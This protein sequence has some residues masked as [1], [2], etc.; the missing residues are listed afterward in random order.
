MKKSLHNLLYIAAAGL[1]SLASCKK[2]QA[3]VTFVGGT[4]P[5]LTATASDSIPLPISDTTATAV[6]FSWTNPNYQFSDGLS[7]MDVTY[8]LEFDTTA[9]FNSGANAGPL[10]T[11]GISSSLSQTYTVAQLNAIVANDMGL[12][13]FNQHS[14]EVRVESFMQP[15][16]STSAPVG[17]LNSA[18]LTFT[19]NPYSPPPA[20]APPPNDSLYIVGSA[21]LP[22]DW[23]NPIPAPQIASETFTEVKPTLYTITTTL[24]GGQEYKLISQN[25]GSW[26]YQWSVASADTYPTGGPFVFNGANC[27]APANT[28]SYTIVVNFQTGIF[29]VTA[30]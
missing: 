23:A 2:D 12:A 4:A 16:T 24:Q 29:T 13:T 19:V 7:S 1:T 3:I 10:A 25:N 30:Q 18:P 11:V 28:G 6:T 17:V 15:F 5:V 21:V 26:T 22:D 8:Y 9:D 20:V 14:L 27:I